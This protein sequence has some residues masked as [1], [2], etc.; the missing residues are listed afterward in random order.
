VRLLLVY[1]ILSLVTSPANKV[2]IGSKM[3]CPESQLKWL[4][5]HCCDNHAGRRPKKLTKK[6]GHL[7]WS[8]SV[9]HSG[10]VAAQRCS[11]SGSV[12]TIHS[13]P[14]RLRFFPRLGVGGF[15]GLGA[16]KVAIDMSAFNAVPTDSGSNDSKNPPAG[17]ANDPNNVK[18]KVAWT[19]DQL[20]DAP[21]FQYYEPPGRTAST[22]SPATTGS[23]PRPTA[24]AAPRPPDTAA[25]VA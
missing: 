16:K 18:L 21:D 3:R 6:Q 15:L 4:A 12:M 1:S 13:H 14:V 10:F 7:P 2:R 19:K 5:L 24:P 22:P 23:A 20:Q 25:L 8:G 9:P 11:N 17:N